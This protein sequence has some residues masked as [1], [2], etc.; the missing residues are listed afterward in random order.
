MIFKCSAVP[1]DHMRMISANILEKQFFPRMKLAE[2][3]NYFAG[4]GFA[5]GVYN[6]S[7]FLVKLCFV[8]IHRPTK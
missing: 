7:C 8:T 3:K 1:F 5:S 6:A 4:V 2:M